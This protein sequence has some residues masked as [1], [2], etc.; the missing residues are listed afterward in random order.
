[1]NVFKLCQVVPFLL[2]CKLVP[3]GVPTTMVPD[4]I[5]QVGWVIELAVGVVGNAITFNVN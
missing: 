5:A 4:G 2:Y 3:K 1:M